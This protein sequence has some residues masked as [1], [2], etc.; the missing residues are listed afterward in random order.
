MIISIII[1]YSV[2]LQNEDSQAQSN[3][4]THRVALINLDIAKIT[5]KT[6]DGEF[7][8]LGVLHIKLFVNIWKTLG[9]IKS[10]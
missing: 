7:L 8:V 1:Q 10:P 4:S 9:V 5:H 2:A 6:V 3:P